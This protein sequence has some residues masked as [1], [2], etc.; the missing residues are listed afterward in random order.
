MHLGCV[1]CL[2]LLTFSVFCET[3]FFTRHSRPMQT[4]SL[5]YACLYLYSSFIYAFLFCLPYMPRMHYTLFG[6]YAAYSVSQHDHYFEILVGVVNVDIV[7]AFSFHLK[8]HLNK[9]LYRKFVGL[10]YASPAWCLTVFSILFMPL[11]LIPISLVLL[12]ILTGLHIC[13]CSISASPV[14]LAGDLLPV[15]CCGGRDGILRGPFSGHFAV[16][17]FFRRAELGVAPARCGI[18]LF[19]RFCRRH[20]DICGGWQR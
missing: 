6:L 18:L 10:L 2:L 16:S 1:F 20:F 8:Q 12:S 4:F 3:L 11:T 14:V 19:S 15:S 5:L 17:F 7:A 9:L 13:V